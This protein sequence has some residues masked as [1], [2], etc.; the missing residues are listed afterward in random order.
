MRKIN[1][2]DHSL[3]K[4]DEAF[5][6][7]HVPSSTATIVAISSQFLFNKPLKFIP[8]R[9]LLLIMSA[10]LLFLQ[11]NKKESEKR[12]METQQTRAGLDVGWETPQSRMEEARCCAAEDAAVRRCCWPAVV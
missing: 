5:K 9:S 2:D 10:V 3:C 4:H 1:N 7:F 12:Q 8:R 11:T 6:G